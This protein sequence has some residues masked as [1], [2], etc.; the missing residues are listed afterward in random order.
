MAPSSTIN[1]DE[2]ASG[3]SRRVE[4]DEMRSACRFKPAMAVDDAMTR[5]M[6][7]DIDFPH[8]SLF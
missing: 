5:M 2:V 1:D 7:G 4:T 8:A 3:Q 6:N